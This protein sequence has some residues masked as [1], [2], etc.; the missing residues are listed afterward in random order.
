LD[1]RR[2]LGGIEGQPDKVRETRF[3]EAIQ[4]GRNRALQHLKAD[5]RDA[6]ALF[7]MTLATGMQA[8]FTGILE[9]RLVKSLSLTREAEGYAK[10][11]LA[12][13][14]DEADA[15]LA[16]G[17]ANYIIGSLPA[18]KRFFLWFGRHHGDKRLG[19][20]QLQITADKEHYLKS[21]AKI[22]LALAAL[23]EKQEAVARRQLSDLAARYPQNP[24]FAAELARLNRQATPVAKSRGD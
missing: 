3:E 15:W 21:F 14:P 11:L 18:Y 6:N 12:L 4:R 19:M 2:L 20:E 24:L 23:R 17:A 8:D 22:F 13:R 5:P 9:K 1:D 16:L 10:Q 7:V